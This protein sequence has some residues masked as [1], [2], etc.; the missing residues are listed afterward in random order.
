MPGITDDKPGRA[1]RRKQRSAPAHLGVFYSCYTSAIYSRTTRLDFLTTHSYVLMSWN[2]LEYESAPVNT[3]VKQSGQDFLRF[4]E[5][6]FFRGDC[7][8]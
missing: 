1:V 5:S 6:C 8:S 3:Y 4:C 7:C 2:V